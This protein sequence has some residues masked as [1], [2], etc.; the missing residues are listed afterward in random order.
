MQ[1]LTIY[2]KDF[3]LTDAIR[4]H[5]EDKISAL[6]KY[7]NHEEETTNF[8]LRLGKVSNHHQHG[9]IYYAE[10]SIHTPEKNYGSRIEAENIYVAVDLLK[11]ELAENISQQR[12]KART[13]SKKEAQKFKHE[14]HASPIEE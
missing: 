11:D 10:L 9:K 8:H 4:S 13:L 1:N 2:C 14:L 5:A 6:Y 7:I 3:D 12:D